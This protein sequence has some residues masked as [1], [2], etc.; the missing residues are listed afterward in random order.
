MNNQVQDE[1]ILKLLRIATATGCIYITELK[2]ISGMQVYEIG[3]RERVSNNA[4]ARETYHFLAIFSDFLEWLRYVDD[5]FSGLSLFLSLFLP[6][7]NVL[8]WCIF[9]FEYRKWNSHSQLIHC[10]QLQ[11]SRRGI[12]DCQFWR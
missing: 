4:R 12:H 8:K 10:A 1:K 7:S 6:F 11:E 2:V 3:R 5:T 9:Q